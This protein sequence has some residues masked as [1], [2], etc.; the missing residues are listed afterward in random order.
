MDHFPLPKD[1][2]HI[3]VPNAT[4]EE[5]SHGDGGFLAY[6]NDKLWSQEELLGERSFGGRSPT[7]VQAFFQT[8]LYFG[9]VI[10]VLKITGVEST[11]D[12]FLDTDKQ[13]VTT[14]NLP[15]KI[16]QWKRNVKRAKESKQKEKL[17]RWVIDIEAILGVL[18]KFIN[19]YSGAPGA[20]SGSEVAKSGGKNWPVSEEITMSIIALGFTLRQAL[21]NFNGVV[22]AV[23]LWGPSHLLETCMLQAGWCPMDV[24]RSLTDIGIDGHYYIAASRNPQGLQYHARCTAEVCSASSIN[25]DTYVTKHTDECWSTEYCTDK[26]VLVDIDCVV[27]ILKDGGIPL[28]SWDATENQLNVKAYNPSKGLQLNYIT[29]SHV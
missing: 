29:I 20:R 10:E 11:K 4:F 18:A 28:V 12:D 16:R 17:G 3:R 23:N 21:I 1:K 25:E 26:H 19:Y 5:Y 13:F 8:W 6:P 7:S 9:C 14:K 15:S 2:Q 27:E 24:R 22:R